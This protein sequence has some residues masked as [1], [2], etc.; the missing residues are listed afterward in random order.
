MMINL[1]KHT[2]DTYSLVNIMGDKNYVKLNEKISEER[3]LL[4]QKIVNANSSRMS[5]AGNMFTHVVI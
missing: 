3:V 5:T 2:T 1:L 4:L